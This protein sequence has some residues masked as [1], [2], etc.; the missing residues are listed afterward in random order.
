MTRERR[1]F[2]LAWG[3]TCVALAA[4]AVLP[5]C[6][7]SGRKAAAKKDDPGLFI[8]TVGGK[9]G[10]ID[11]NGAVVIK[12]QFDKALRFS[13]GLAPVYVGEQAGFIDTAGRFVIQPVFD[14]A[15]P[16]TEGLAVASREG[17]FCF[18][19]TAGREVAGAR[20]T[21]FEEPG[22]FLKRLEQVK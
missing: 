22:E 2:A 6:D 21:G 10:Y 11:K 8:V 15:L 9:Q 5:S 16:F 14:F 12:P 17:L 1:G 20:L 3:A 19:D 13:E 7:C 18:L 4:S